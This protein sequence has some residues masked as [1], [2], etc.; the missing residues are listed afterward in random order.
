MKHSDSI[1]M[2]VKSALNPQ[3]SHFPVTTVTE[4]YLISKA[5]VPY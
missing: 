3:D 5:I 1:Y 4:K 2:K